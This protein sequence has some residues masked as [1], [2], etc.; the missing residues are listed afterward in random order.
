MRRRGR[1]RPFEPVD[2]V[3]LEVALVDGKE[4]FGWPGSNKI[5]EP[6]LSNLIG[7]G[8]AIS[9]GSFALLA[10]S[11]FLSNAA[12]FTFRGGTELNGAT[13]VRFDYEV[14]PAVSVY[15][16]E[17]DGS[18]AVVGYH[19][20]FWANP[21]TLD[22]LRLE[23]RAD[24]I[25]AGLGLESTRDAMEYARVRI[26]SGDFLLPKSSELSMTATSGLEER[27]HTDFAQCRQFS[28]ESV[29]SFTDPDE[30]K[31][32]PAP[33]PVIN[34]DLPADF[35]S[36]IVLNTRITSDS[37]VGDTVKAR[38]LHSI[39][40]HH[41]ILFA[42]GAILTGYI[43]QLHR[44]DGGLYHI[45]ISFTDVE[46]ERK[47]ADLSERQ[48]TLFLSAGLRELRPVSAMNPLHRG[49]LHHAAR[50]AGQITVA[51]EKPL[52]LKPGFRMTLRSRL[53]QSGK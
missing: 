33:P 15:H 51:S 47:H 2:R 3:R 21:D 52:D 10:K 13:A 5:A 37:A 34:V 9:N 40:E 53:L 7:A 38:L 31:A 14:A 50:A 16:L 6:D 26:G 30:V 39:R 24:H 49:F 8:G 28:G 23:I 11:V 48:N 36:D 4:L 12:A 17:V 43:S 45:G 18:D 46:Y 35:Q 29:L 41:K 42:K 22:L 19:G 27:N 32:A 25:P 44:E 20:S 1:G